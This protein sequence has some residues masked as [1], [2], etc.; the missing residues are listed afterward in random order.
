MMQIGEF[1]RFATERGFFGYDDERFRKIARVL[2]RHPD[3]VAEGFNAVTEDPSTRG[4]GGVEV[5]AIDVTFLLLAGLA[6]A[7]I[8][9]QLGERCWRLYTAP[10]DNLEIHK[11][12]RPTRLCPVTR[13]ET[14]GQALR[15]I[16]LD[17]KLAARVV[18]V[19]LWREWDEIDIVW[20]PETGQ[21]DPVWS[22]FVHT[23]I[24]NETKGL[25][26]KGVA[27]GE[28][29]LELALLELAKTGQPVTQRKGN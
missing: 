22:M 11:G 4:K 23:P 2:I 7:A 28:M 19:T 6:G 8:N 16:L 17:P 15:D 5:A 25:V 1:R 21:T 24:L 3:I 10:S 27:R 29:L 12:R 18:D 26:T 13:R 9:E 14:A 20:K